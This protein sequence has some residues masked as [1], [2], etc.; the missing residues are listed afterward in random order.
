MTTGRKRMLIARARRGAA[1]GAPRSP[2]TDACAGRWIGFRPALTPRGARLQLGGLQA[3]QALVERHG[4]VAEARAPLRERGVH[5]RGRLEAVA[6]DVQARQDLQRG[7]LRS[8]YTR[9][10]KG[11][12]KRTAF[13]LRRSDALRMR[14]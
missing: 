10:Y 11:L 5:R 4:R 7:H 12:Q 1:H 14:S 3:V 6:L 13:E 9:V 8:K 2:L